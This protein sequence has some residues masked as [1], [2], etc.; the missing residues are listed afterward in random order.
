M[1]FFWRCAKFSEKR[2]FLQFEPKMTIFVA[3]RSV[4]ARFVYFLRKNK[5]N[6]TWSQRCRHLSKVTILWFSYWSC[7]SLKLQSKL[8]RIFFS[9]LN[10]NLIVGPRSIRYSLIE[11]SIILKNLLISM[12][13]HQSLQGALSR[14]KDVIIFFLRHSF[15]CAPNRKKI[16]L[17]LFL[18]SFTK[19]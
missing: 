9:K 5:I 6:W 3:N 8:N 15:Q 18:A 14:E 4:K 7:R 16:V 19:H 10:R 13:F 2:T 1:C 12:R 11:L 17:N